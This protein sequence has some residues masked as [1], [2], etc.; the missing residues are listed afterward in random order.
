MGRKNPTIHQ[1]VAQMHNMHGLWHSLESER[2]HMPNF[3]LH[4]QQ[5]PRFKDDELTVCLTAHVQHPMTVCLTAHVQHP[6]ASH[7]IRDSITSILACD[8]SIVCNAIGRSLLRKSTSGCSRRQQSND[9]AVLTHPS[10]AKAKQS[11]AKPSKAN[12]VCDQACTSHKKGEML[13]T[14]KADCRQACHR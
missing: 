10:K 7:T 14:L 3:T 8:K 11:K 4:L 12:R 9:H 13:V 5:T 6:T 2:A 1:G